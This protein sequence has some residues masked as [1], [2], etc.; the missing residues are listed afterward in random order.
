MII[1][2]KID[3]SSCYPKITC[4]AFSFGRICLYGIKDIDKDEKDG[5]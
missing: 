3:Q 2:Q 5:D 1:L 4:Q